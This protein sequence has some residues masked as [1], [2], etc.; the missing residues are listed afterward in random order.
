MFVAAEDVALNAKSVKN[1]AETV[2]SIRTRLM[3]IGN[4][5]LFGIMAETGNMPIMDIKSIVC[6]LSVNGD[7][8]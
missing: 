6:R 3:T 1:Q 8:I 7:D 4:G 5:F 2:R